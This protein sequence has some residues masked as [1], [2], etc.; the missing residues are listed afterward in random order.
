LR[1]VFREIDEPWMDREVDGLSSGEGLIWAIRDP[2]TKR[3]PI[4]TKGR[5]IGYQSVIEDDGVDDKRLFV[6][7]SEFATVTQVLKRQGNTLSPVLRR[8]WDSRPKL[9][10]LTKNSPAVASNPHVSVIGHITIREL[11]R[12]ITATDAANGF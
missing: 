2:I 5:I 7:Q 6:L 12:E 4:K 8:A 11:A 3:H 1:R 10:S 9:Q